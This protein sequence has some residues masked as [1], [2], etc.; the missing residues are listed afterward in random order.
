[1]PRLIAIPGD[2]NVAHCTAADKEHNWCSQMQHTQNSPCATLD[3]LNRLH[4]R[5]TL[6]AAREHNISSRVTIVSKETQKMCCPRKRSSTILTSMIIRTAQI[7]LQG[8]HYGVQCKM[9]GTTHKW[10][11]TWWTTMSYPHSTAFQSHDPVAATAQNPEELKKL[12][13]HLF[14]TYAHQSGPDLQR[15]STAPE[16]C[17]KQR[18]TPIVLLST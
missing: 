2:V 5:V 15:P 8:N 12:H 14:D 9:V 10:L 16:A 3:S 18:L 1:M 6:W 13:S 7:S 11:K 4:H 17:T